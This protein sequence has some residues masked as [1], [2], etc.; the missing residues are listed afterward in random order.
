MTACCVVSSHPPRDRRSGFPSVPKPRTVS[1]PRTNVNFFAG[2]EVL[3]LLALVLF[4][5]T[6]EASHVQSRN[7][8]RDTPGRRI[9]LPAWKRGKPPKLDD[10]ANNVA[11]L[12]VS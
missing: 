2:F 11:A 9:L 12:A 8:T 10:Q 7:R 5:G 6:S 3:R 4:F 1:K